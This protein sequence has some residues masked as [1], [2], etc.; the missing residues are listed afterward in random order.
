MIEEE[1]EGSLIFALPGHCL[2][3]ILV[4]YASMTSSLIVSVYRYRVCGEGGQRRVFRPGQCCFVS[5]TLRVLVDV[6]S[7]VGTID[8]RRNVEEMNTEETAD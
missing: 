6:M 1:K 3:D 7:K 5:R 4:R 8:P 2:A